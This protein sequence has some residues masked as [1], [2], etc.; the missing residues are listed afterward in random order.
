MVELHVNVNYKGIKNC[1][2]E[3]NSTLGEMHTVHFGGGRPP[4]KK[5]DIYSIITIIYL[6]RYIWSQYG[7]EHKNG[8][9]DVGVIGKYQF[10]RI[11][12][13]YCL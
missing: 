8:T 12:L 1:N 11:L 9:E 5:N 2:H 7:K 10:P 4:T 3:N 13:E 6:K